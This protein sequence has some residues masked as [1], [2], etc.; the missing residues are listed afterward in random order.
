MVMMPPVATAPV[1]AAPIAGSPA[2]RRAPVAGIEAAPTP[3]EAEGRT[4]A[5]ITGRTV[6]PRIIPTAVPAAIPAVVPRVIV[7]A[8]AVADVHIDTYV[9]QAIGII[10][11]VAITVIP[12]TQIQIDL[13]C[14]GNRY[15]AR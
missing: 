11:I 9:G 7:T 12:V 4:V 8:P 15:L 10:R 6:D 13:V 1:T 2:P 3:A 14:S 5:P